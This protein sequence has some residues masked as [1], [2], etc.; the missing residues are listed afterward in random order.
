M[1]LVLGGTRF[2]GRHIVERLADRGHDV[3]CFHR[4]TT[5]CELLAGVRERF[6]D[7]AGDLASIENDRWDAVIDVNAYD[8]ALVERSVRLRTDRYALVS[9]VNVYHDLSQ[10]GVN[11][12]SATIEAFD[13]ADEAQRYGGNKAACERIVFERFGGDRATVVRPGL[14]VG[15]WDYTGRFSYWPLRALRGGE[16]AVA[17]PPDRRVQFIDAA[18]IA[19]FVVQAMEREAGGAYNLVGPQDATTMRELLDAC[20]QGARER[21]APPTTV[22]WIDPALLHSMDVKPWME[23]PL[24]L[25]EPQYAGIL[26]ID[27]AK[28]VGAGLEYRPLEETVGG[29][30]N[31][32]PSG[33]EGVGLTEEREAE[34]LAAVQRA[35]Q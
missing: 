14:I 6:G 9:T 12:E 26:E 16:I 31:W 3:V 23:M 1:I 35:T 7:R 22:R 13:P 11:E 18:D 28:A 25:D 19:R 27:N 8:P 24:W 20:L 15:K 21:G 2:L 29:V 17:G 10:A 30:M 4:G 34:I 5:T 33:I 32:R